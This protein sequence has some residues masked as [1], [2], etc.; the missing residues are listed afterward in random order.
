MNDNKLIGGISGLYT[1]AHNKHIGGRV[2]R[3]GSGSVSGEAEDLFA[4]WLD[5]VLKA[6]GVLIWVNP[7]IIFEKRVKTSATGR[8]RKDYFKPDICVVEG[9]E[10]TEKTVRLLFE[11]KMDLSRLGDFGAYAKKRGGI[12]R[13]LHRER[14]HCRVCSVTYDLSFEK[15]LQWIYAVFSP[16]Y[17]RK[18]RM[19]KF[20]KKFGPSFFVLGN[21]HP[22]DDPASFKPD[23]GAFE[24]LK[25]KILSSI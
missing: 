11:L 14:A 3:G 7:T 12:V 10:G 20:K 15:G 16:E 23:P 22:N 5:G 4:L 2:Y 8:E 18:D 21:G 13:G 25:T 9:E 1:K 17:C 24:A 6:R 19:E